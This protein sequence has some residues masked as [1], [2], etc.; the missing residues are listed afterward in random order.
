MALFLIPLGYWAVAAVGTALG[1]GAT[2]AATDAVDDVADAATQTADAFASVA[3]WT[4]LAG[5]AYAAYQ[6]RD[7]LKKVLFK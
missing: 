3:K 2:I 6:N 4:L 7:L 1:I 5:T